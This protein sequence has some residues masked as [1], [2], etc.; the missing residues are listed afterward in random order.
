[1]GNIC[2][3][4]VNAVG[5]GGETYYTHCKDTQELNNWIEVNREKL[6]L[7]ELKI[8]DKNKHPIFNWFHLRKRFK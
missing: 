8:T 1:M 7:N 5:K 2:R 4:V 6:L 3:Y